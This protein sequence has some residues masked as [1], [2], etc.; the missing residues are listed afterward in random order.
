MAKRRFRVEFEDGEGAK[1]TISLDGDL[2]R[3]KVLK[4][5]DMVE[6]LGG[7]KEPAP[8]ISPDTTLGRLYRLIEE[9][10]PVGYSTST[11][12]QELYEDEYQRP[13]RLSTVSTYLS[14]LSERGLL[15]RERTHSGLA[16]RRVRIEQRK[17]LGE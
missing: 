16:Y 1:Y 7:A 9:R 8:Q 10:F 12:I 11:D 3:E 5:L 13:I 2:S 17:I 6:L 4:I 15:K 14:R